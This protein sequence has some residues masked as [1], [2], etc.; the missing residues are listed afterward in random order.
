M[1]EEAGGEE[2]IAWDSGDPAKGVATMRKDSE[3]MLV[4][5]HNDVVPRIQ[6][7]ALEEEY[8]LEHP[9]L[10]VP[11]LGYIDLRSGY[12]G[13]VVEPNG[14]AHSAWIA[15]RVLDTKTGKQANSKL[16]PSW[17]FRPPCTGR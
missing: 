6:P 3:R 15:D 16:K 7:I 10:R 11:L 8:Y 5:Y 2:E 4:R 9:S 12:E 14:E 13:E 17:Q 1:L